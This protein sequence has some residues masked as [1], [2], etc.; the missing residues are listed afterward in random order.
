M[1]IRG[2]YYCANYNERKT[3]FNTG[4]VQYVE[5]KTNAKILSGKKIKIPTVNHRCIPTF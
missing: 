1:H 3:R 4:T 2:I 5:K